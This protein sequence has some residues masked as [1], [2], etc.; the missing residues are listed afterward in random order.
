MLKVW[1]LLEYGGKPSIVG[2]DMTITNDTVK[3]MSITW[4]LSTA[5]EAETKAQIDDQG[6]ITVTLGTKGGT[7]VAT[8]NDVVK[9]LK[10][11]GIKAKAPNNDRINPAMIGTTQTV[12]KGLID[13][14]KGI[15]ISTQIAASKAIS[16]IDNAINTVSNERAK[17]GAIQNRLEHTINNLNTSAENLTS[18]E[19]RIRDV[20]MAKE[21]MEMTKNN[22]LQQAAQSMLAQANQNPQNVLQL[23]R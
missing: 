19:S 20:D 5:Q 21:M 4:T 10:K 17:M 14:R 16:V 9:S 18:A 2:G 13:N 7:L 11:I 3:D 15:S 8:K 23:L 22:I 1:V 6:N 12:S